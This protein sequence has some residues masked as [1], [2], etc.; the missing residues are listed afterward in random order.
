MAKLRPIEF[1]FPVGGLDTRW[2]Y[3]DQP[4]NTTP[5]CQN[6]R[7]REALGNRVRGGVRPGLTKLYTDELGSGNPVRLLNQVTVARSTGTSTSVDADSDLFDRVGSTLG[8]GWTT[9]SWKSASC[10]TVA[11]DD[12]HAFVAAGVDAGNVRQDLSLDVSGTYSLK[13]QIQVPTRT[14]PDTT[15]I[16]LF[17]RMDDSSPDASADGIQARL[18]II[19]GEDSLTSSGDLIDYV[20]SAVQST[21]TYSG[22]TIVYGPN[23]Y[24]VSV[25]GNA[26]TVK[27]NG[28]TIATKTVSAH[29]DSRVGMGIN[30]ITFA[31]QDETTVLQWFVSYTTTADASGFRT[32]LVASSNGA[33]NSEQSPGDMSS[34]VSGNVANLNSSSALLSA[35]RGQKLYIADYGSARLVNTAGTFAGNGTDLTATGVTDWTTYGINV[36]TDVVVVSAG[37]GDVVDGTYEISSVVTAKLVTTATVGGA[38]NCTLRVE[39]HPKIYDPV[40]DSASLWIATAGIVPTGCPIICLYRDRLMLAGA[41][42]DPHQ[43]YMAKQGYPLNFDYTETGDGRA[44]Y[45]GSGTAGKIGD[46]ITAM[47]PYSD[48]LLFFGCL[49]S[50]HLLRGDPAMVGQLGEISDEIG[51]I[52]KL[53]WAFDPAGRVYFLSNHGLYRMHMAA[54]DTSL[55]NVSETHLPSEFQGISRDNFDCLLYWDEEERGV[56]IFLTPKDAVGGTHYFYDADLDAFWKDSYASAHGPTAAHDYDSVNEAY[57][58]MIVGGRDG[59]LRY[60]NRQAVSDDGT[61]ISSHVVYP[62]QLLGDPLHEG[63]LMQ[64]QATLAD[65]TDGCDW[66]VRV[67]RTAELAVAA[68]A[69]ASGSWTSGGMQYQEYPRARGG[70]VALKLF[71]TSATQ[72][73]AVESMLGIVKPVGRHRKP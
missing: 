42:S 6:V 64:L 43:W 54:G 51:I 53:A 40:A 18:R 56:H 22:G 26:I 23:W 34:V 39:R 46:V 70:A 65:D 14:S 38:G 5:D 27:L 13:V 19:R 24:E 8:A 73:W 71:N 50:T 21:T 12:G 41:E 16:Y 4:E 10:K 48:D 45:G 20:G 7:G 36:D 58:H 57:R 62:P 9:A 1:R 33:I 44:M 68:S 37:T 2:A 28:T 11:I 61:A 67:A 29:T 47:I 25:N 66:E 63:I 55:E 30:N 32:Y 35:E 31:G 49:G 15:E 52:D 69:F 72:Q 3:Q 60:G 59:Y 17:A